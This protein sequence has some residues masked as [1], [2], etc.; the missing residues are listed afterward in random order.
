MKRGEGVINTIWAFDELTIFDLKKK[1]FLRQGK[2]VY[3]L[4]WD[5]E[6]SV[7]RQKHKGPHEDLTLV[8][9][10]SSIQQCPL[11]WLKAQ[12]TVWQSPPQ[13]TAQHTPLGRD[14][15]E[16]QRPREMLCHSTFGRL[17]VISKVFRTG[18]FPMRL[19]AAQAAVSTAGF[20]SDSRGNAHTMLLAV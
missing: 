4:P 17:S 7:T 5:E 20:H 15:R 18:S 2:K 14:E 6:N 8:S 3:V 13:S 1:L 10:G 16:R 9:P 12:S 11:R 19:C